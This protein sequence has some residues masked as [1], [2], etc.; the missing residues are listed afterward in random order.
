MENCAKIRIPENFL[1]YLWENKLCG[2]TF[3]LGDGKICR[4]LAPGISGNRDGPDFENAEI[5]ID[6]QRWLGFVEIHVKSSDWYR[7][8]H[9]LDAV[10]DRIILH[11]VAENDKPVKNNAG[12]IIP[13]IVLVEAEH[14]FRFWSSVQLAPKAPLLCHE[15]LGKLPQNKLFEIIKQSAQTRLERKAKQVETIF[16]ESGGDW[17]QTAWRVVA[18]AYGI[19]K[20]VAPMEWLARS[21]GWKQLAGISSLFSVEALLFGQA[22]MLNQHFDRN[23]QYELKLQ[24]EYFH[25]KNKFGL[26]SIDETAW[27]Y[28][29]I[30]P[31]AFPDVRIAQ[32]AALVF[33]TRNLLEIILDSTNLTAFYQAFRHPVSDYWE[34]HCRLGAESTPQMSSIVGKNSIDIFLIN[35]IVPFMI[36]YS[37]W[38]SRNCI[39]SKAFGLL[40]E[41]GPEKNKIINTFVLEAGIEL[42][43]AY[44]TQGLIELYTKSCIRRKCIDCPALLEIMNTK[45]YERTSFKQK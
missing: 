7:H 20:N 43:S 19:S 37:K 28:S 31:P 12:E 42:N 27:K 32:L 26:V 9:H 10:Y 15:H 3:S 18:A 41:I 34:K 14:L 2:N 39:E 21:V 11:V 25:L 23:Q 17:H 13:T 22:G 38:T 45:A 36:F 24:A 5:E 16:Q 4:V 6:G 33:S 35:A 8:L 1:H 40:S 30:R 29:P 44:E